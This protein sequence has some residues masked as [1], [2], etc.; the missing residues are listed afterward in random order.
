MANAKAKKTNEIQ[1]SED[2]SKLSKKLVCIDI[3]NDLDLL[4][5]EPTEKELIEKLNQIQ[6]SK[7]NQLSSIEN[8]LQSLAN[9]NNCEF[10]IYITRENLVDTFKQIIDF[11]FKYQDVPML[12][13]PP[14][15]KL[16]EV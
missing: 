12:R 2:N 10:G 4:E 14:Q 3:V 7:Q 5:R 6:L 15:I 9:S 8:E 13:I 11:F 16:K 1:K